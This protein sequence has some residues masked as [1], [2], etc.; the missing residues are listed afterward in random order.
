MFFSLRPNTQVFAHEELIIF[1]CGVLQSFFL[2]I[3]LVV[4]FLCISNLQVLTLL[5]SVCLVHAKIESLVEIKT[6]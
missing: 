6:M 3:F 4:D 2:Y 5:F 1:R